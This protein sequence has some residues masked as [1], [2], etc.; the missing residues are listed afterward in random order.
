M[1][2]KVLF[3]LLYLHPEKWRHDILKHD[4][5][6]GLLLT[7]EQFQQLIICRTMNHVIPKQP[8][9]DLLLA[10]VLHEDGLFRC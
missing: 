5:K 10:F 4:I 3:V 8:M 7:D 6:I 2:G 9:H 1:D